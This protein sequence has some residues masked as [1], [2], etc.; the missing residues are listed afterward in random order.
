M[1]FQ[2][3]ILRDQTKEMGLTGQNNDAKIS[4]L[5]YCWRN[6]NHEYKF[7]LYSYDNNTKLNGTIT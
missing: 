2:H 1:V 7:V 3:D 5:K 6:L 4:L